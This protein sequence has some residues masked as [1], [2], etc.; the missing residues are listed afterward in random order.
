MTPG[1]SRP[2]APEGFDLNDFEEAVTES[3]VAGVQ[4][5]SLECVIKGNPGFAL[6]LFSAF[7]E[8]LRRDGVIET[9][10]RRIAIL[11]RDALSEY[12]SGLSGL[13]AEGQLRI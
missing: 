13:A 6:R 7:S 4:K 2:P 3:R 12:A 5:A 9:R 11:D 10:S 8:R 1:G